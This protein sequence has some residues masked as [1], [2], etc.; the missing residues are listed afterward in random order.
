MRKTVII[1]AGLA[2]LSAGYYA[3]KKKI[4]YEIYEK[5]DGVGGLCRTRKKERFSFDYSGHLLHLKD[6]YSQSLIKSLLGHNLNVIQRNSFIYSHKVFTRY[7][8][9]ANLYGLPPDVVKECLMEFVRAYYENEDLPTEAYKTFH[10]W[11]VGKLGK[12]I[13]KYFM[14]PY[15]EKLWTIPPGELTCGWMSEYVPKPTLEDVFH[16]TFSDQKKGFGYNAT[17]WYP[18]KGG[19]QALCDALADKV[20][21]I[22]LQEKVERIFHKKKIIEFDSGKTT[23]Y[24]KLISTMPLKKLVERL[25]GDIPQEVKDAAQKLKHNSVLIINLGVKGEG[26]TDKHWIYLPEKKYTVYRIGVYSNFSEYMAPPG[27]TSYY[28]E[29]AY[30]KDWNIDKEKTVENALDEIVEIGFV[31]HRKDILVK[32]IMDIECAYVIYDRYYSESKKIIMDY[33]N[34]VNIYSIGRYGN[35]EYSGM[36]EAMHQGKESIGES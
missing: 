35:W 17:F 24:E 13:G 5:D 19:I 6:P 32:E 28:I 30:Q 2:G 14:F 8:F 18:K 20:R 10:E 33:L 34:S 15:N 26:L 23:A 29:I 21:N 9:Q 3:Q 4:D 22:R 31:P 27:T 16:G 7:P 25:D 11:I 1:G 36:E 12:G